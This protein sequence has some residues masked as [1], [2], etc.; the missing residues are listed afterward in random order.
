LPGL[1]A[2]DGET[3]PSSVLP[4]LTLASAGGAVLLGQEFVRGFGSS[5][6][7]G[8]ASSVALRRQLADV[9]REERD[10]AL[11][12][13]GFPGHVPR[14]YRIREDQPIFFARR[15]DRWGAEAFDTIPACPQGAACG[16]GEN[17]SNDALPDRARVV[18]LAVP[19]GWFTE[20]D[21][22]ALGLRTSTG[23]EVA[24]VRVD[25]RLHAG[26]AIVV[27]PPDC[28]SACGPTSA[29]GTVV[30]E[31]VMHAPDLMLIAPERTDRRVVDGHR[32]PAL[33]LRQDS[34]TDPDADP[35][36]LLRTRLDAAGET[37]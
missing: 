4:R 27:V 1:Q 19:D 6:D 31:G 26:Q 28:R 22:H 36:S 7:A 16:R 29:S 14:F 13:V 20:A 15:G 5:D 33:R 37:P 3:S 35:V 23:G 34:R 17:A 8:A 12:A 9:N 24:T 30:V 25:A 10:R 21:G 2:C 11:D 32:E 18:T